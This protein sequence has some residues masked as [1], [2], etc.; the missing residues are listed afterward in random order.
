MNP[1]A[2]HPRIRTAPTTEGTVP[3][4]RRTGTCGQTAR[5]DCPVPATFPGRTGARATSFS[6]PRR[7][8]AGEPGD[9]GRTAS[10]RTAPPLSPEQ[11][12]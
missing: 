4:D 7:A 6:W 1:L 2:P 3:L 11:P 8:M 9:D 10:S 12:S 5:T